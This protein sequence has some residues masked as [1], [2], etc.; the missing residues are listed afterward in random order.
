M[1]AHA[2]LICT[3]DLILRTVITDEDIVKYFEDYY[4]SAEALSRDSE[5]II[6]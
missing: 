1:Q 6:I 5:F 3:F 2:G 4:E